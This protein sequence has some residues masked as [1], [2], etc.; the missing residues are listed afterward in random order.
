[1]STPE[2]RSEK[3][4]ERKTQFKLEID[5]KKDFGDF[6]F[7]PPIV[8]CCKMAVLNLAA[9]SQHAGWILSVAYPFS[10][11][12]STMLREDTYVDNGNF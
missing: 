6:M 12:V 10:S 4:V 9:M 2:V 7:V 1:L 8:L 5:D 11:S 3:V